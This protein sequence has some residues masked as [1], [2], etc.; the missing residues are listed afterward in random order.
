MFNGRQNISSFN[1]LQYFTRLT[2]IYVRAF[3]NSSITET[4]VPNGVTKLSTECLRLCSSLKTLVLPASL[5]A[6]D[7]YALYQISA[8]K[9]VLIYATTPPAMNG[10]NGFPNGLTAIHV[11]APSVNTY[12]SASWWSNYAA[13]IVA[14]EE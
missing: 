9:D 11:P 4:I 14:I 10:T 6:I 3:Y 1:E 7:N 5:T 2:Q 13:K 8:M 12:K